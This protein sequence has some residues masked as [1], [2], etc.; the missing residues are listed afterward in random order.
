MMIAGFAV[1]IFV[2]VL[3]F[4]S[5]I[6]YRRKKGDQSLPTQTHE[7]IGLEI[8]YTI[9]PLIMVLVIFFF[10]VIV[11]NRVDDV[12]KK[13]QV[14]VNVTAYQWGWIFHYSVPDSNIVVETAPNAAPSALAQSY[15]DTSLYPQ[16]V[17]PDNETTRFFL[18]SNDVI[19]GFFVHAFNFSR[20]AQPGVVNQ[21]EIEPTS[22]GVFPA[23][24]TQ[25]CGLYHSEMLFS[26]KVVTPGQFQA[27]INQQEQ[28]LAVRASSNSTGSAP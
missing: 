18:R 5:I 26:V 23:Q 17:L 22:V 3:I 1:A 8:T 2:W 16:L 9:V 27:W 15:T 20:Y 12:L 11:E 10:T 21:F 7:H 25:Y 13:P 4:W 19:H 6:R 28:K 14:I 24:C